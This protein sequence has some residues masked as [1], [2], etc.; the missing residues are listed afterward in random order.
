MEKRND[1]LQIRRKLLVCGRLLR[2]ISPSCLSGL[3]GVKDSLPFVRRSVRDAPALSYT[4]GPAW[5]PERKFRMTR[6][7]ALSTMLVGIMVFLVGQS[8][9]GTIAYLTSQADVG[10]NIIGSAKAFAPTDLTAVPI[11][12]G[13]LVLS[14][15]KATWATQGY[16]LY[17][18]DDGLSF[19]QITT[20]ATTGPSTFTYTEVLGHKDI[21]NTPST[22]LTD[23]TLYYYVVR[24]VSALSGTGTDSTQVQVTP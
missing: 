8:A 23:G 5:R 10:S 12:G 2:R 11:P 15:G 19:Y 21:N 4:S 13:G 9:G 22:A 20:T 6:L 16:Q 3:L 17:R 18:S 1:S 24:G 7:N 14:W